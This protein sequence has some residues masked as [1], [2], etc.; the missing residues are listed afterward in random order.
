[1]DWLQIMISLVFNSSVFLQSS[2]SSQETSKANTEHS[3]IH[4]HRTKINHSYPCGQTWQ[5][6]TE[7]GCSLMRPIR[8]LTTSPQ[9]TLNHTHREWPSPD[10]HENPTPS[11][12][13]WP[14]NMFVCVCV[15]A[16]VTAKCVLCEGFSKAACQQPA[17]CSSHSYSVLP[18]LWK[19]NLAWEE[20][21]HVRRKE[22]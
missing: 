4:T 22:G 10:V 2:L 5:R 1:M 21:E 12:Q 20:E 14:Q 16:T 13:M 7:K 11:E 9:H 18:L 17:D 8:L 6:E 19:C 3:H 15:W